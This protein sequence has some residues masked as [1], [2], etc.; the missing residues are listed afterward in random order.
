MGAEWKAEE[1]GS[2]GMIECRA[3]FIRDPVEKLRYLRHAAGA[4]LPA[5]KRREWPRWRRLTPVLIVVLLLVPI[6]T[7]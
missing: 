5:R 1:T 2:K 6:P 3:R 4:P 7:V